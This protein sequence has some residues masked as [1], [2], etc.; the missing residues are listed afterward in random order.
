[1]VNRS[2]VDFYVK[3]STQV[4]RFFAVLAV[5]ALIFAAGASA[6]ACT[7]FTKQQGDTVLVGN[8]EDWQYSAP[9]SL[10]IVAPGEKTYGRVCF[11]T[12]SYV[13]GGMN[14]KGLFYD[15]ATCPS[16]KVPF[17]EGKRNLGMDFCE[18]ILSECA[19]VQEVIEMVHEINI[20]RGFEDHILFADASG[21]A[22]VVEWVENELRVIPKEGDFQ[23]ITNFWLTK[24]ELGWYPDSRYDQAKMM[25]EK[26]ETLSVASFADIL[27]ATL[28]D[29]GDGG[30][31]YSNI[32]D[33]KKR[34]V[35][36]YL[37]G[38]FSK[39]VRI[40]LADEFKGLKP[41]EK[42]TFRLDALSFKEAETVRD[43]PETQPQPTG[44][45]EKSPSAI[46]QPVEKDPEQAP[47][48][49]NPVQNLA[50][51]EK[52][53]SPLTYVLVSAVLLILVLIAVYYI[54]FRKRKHLH[55]DEA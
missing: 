37:K 49:S 11:A 55:R 16:S 43:F 41:G 54:V 36:I 33:L 12:Y 51:A 30:T 34:E 8:N 26:D 3:H 46:V 45:T 53:Q 4:K 5:L 40:N 15:G 44:K 19:T 32:Y 39:E 47:N 52:S 21:D 38:D 20:P 42:R 9:S 14:E 29:W 28:Q 22:V 1:M 2:L 17:F 13:Q 7:I 50:T 6:D 10:W 23:L 27:K 31:K 24:P 48:A 35:Y 18:V 25:L